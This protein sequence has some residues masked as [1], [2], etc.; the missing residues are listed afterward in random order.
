MEANIGLEALDRVPDTFRNLYSN[1]KGREC[2]SVGSIP[3]QVLR[4]FS[5]EKKISGLAYKCYSNTKDI[6]VNGQSPRVH[7]SS[8]IIN[9]AYVATCIVVVIKFMGTCDARTLSS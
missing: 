8:A 6:D 3:T 9:Y 2:E 1:A 5:N 7:S 4:F